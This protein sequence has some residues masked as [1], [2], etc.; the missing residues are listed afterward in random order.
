LTKESSPLDPGGKLV[1][2]KKFFSEI[3]RSKGTELACY[4]RSAQ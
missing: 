3:A 1:P 4:I 2:A